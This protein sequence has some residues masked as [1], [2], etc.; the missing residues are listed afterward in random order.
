LAKNGIT[1]EGRVIDTE[2]MPVEF[3]K[4]TDGGTTVLKLVV[5][6][7]HSDKNKNAPAKF[8]DPNK[9]GE[10]WVNTTTSW[11]KLTVFGEKAE[12]LALAD[13]FGHSAIVQV[14]NA[15]Y[16][17]EDP[18]TDRGNVVRAGRPETIGDDGSIEVKAKNNGDLLGRSDD[19]RQIWDGGSVPILKGSGGKRSYEVPEDEGF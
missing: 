17:E 7:Q 1:Y 10:D 2:R 11:H 4:F 9:S 13:W 18:W 12:E 19:A 3:G 15:S 8:K 16:K 14:T 5:A 6:E